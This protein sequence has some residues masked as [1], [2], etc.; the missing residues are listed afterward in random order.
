M[1]VSRA[2]RPPPLPSPG[3]PGEGGEVVGELPCDCPGRKGGRWPALGY[4]VMSTLIPT[5]SLPHSDPAMPRI[6]VS[7]SRGCWV[8]L[9]EHPGFRGG[10]LRLFGPA[11]YINLWVAPEEWG[12][13]AG[14]VVSGPAAFVQC[15]NELNFRDSVTWLVP[16]QRIADVARLPA[17]GDLDSIR[18]FDRP[19]FA[20]EPGY[21][22][23]ARHHGDDPPLL[24]LRQGARR[25]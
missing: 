15:F 11:D 5:S 4:R 3:V 21:D 16:G 18:L 23:Y 25:L 19:P 24:K 9:F 22:A 1:S 6:C 20:A 12:E 7:Q 14:S 8:D 17:S 13:A 10:R 2:G